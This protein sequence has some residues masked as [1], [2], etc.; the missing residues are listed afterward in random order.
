VRTLQDTEPTTGIQKRMDI[1]I[2]TSKPYVKVTHRLINRNAWPV[3]LALW[4]L[5]VMARGGTCIIPQA[6]YVPHEKILLPAR[7]L[8]LWPYTVMSDKRWTWGGKFILLKQDPKAKAPQKVGT[9]LENGWAAYVNNGQAFVKRFRHDPKAEYPDMGCSFEAFTNND[10][11]EVESLGP[12]TTI[13][14]GK[15]ARHIEHWFVFDG[16]DIG[17]SETSIEKAMAPLLEQTEEMMK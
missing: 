9:A 10:M 3:R 14:P 17:R 7:P 16:V 5:S 2:H 6:P 1:D 13:Q 4:G 15:S 11:L 8:V 12:M